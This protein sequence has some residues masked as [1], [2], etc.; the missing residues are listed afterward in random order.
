MKRKPAKPSEAEEEA[1]EEPEAEEEAPARSEWDPELDAVLLDLGLVPE[2]TRIHAR[3]MQYDE[4]EPRL[5]LYR[6]GGKKGSTKKRPLTRI[7]LG[8]ARILFDWLSG[9]FS[10]NDELL[11][12]MPDEESE[13]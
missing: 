8:E 13:G 6:A 1:V 3:V 11:A 4:N 10:D 7:P 12:Y 5:H 2:T 9:Q